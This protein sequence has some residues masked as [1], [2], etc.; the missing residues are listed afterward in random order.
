VLETTLKST[1]YRPFEAV[2]IAL[3]AALVTTCAVVAPLH[4]R[5][6]QQA[7][8]RHDLDQLTPRERGLELSSR[9]VLP[10]SFH[11]TGTAIALFPTQL[12][13][14]VPEAARQVFAPPVAGTAVQVSDVPLNPRST[15]GALLWRAG[16]CDHLRFVAGS[17][18]AAAGDIAVSAADAKTHGWRPGTRLRVAEVLDPLVTGKH[19]RARLRVTG[20]YAEPAADDPFWEGIRLS[21]P[22]GS[23]L[24][25]SRHDAWLTAAAT[26]AVTDPDDTWRDPVQTTSYRL[27]GLDVGVD[28]VRAAATGLA[29]LRDRLGERTD[30]QASVELATGLIAEAAAL[31]RAQHQAQVVVPLLMVPLGLLGLVVLW[32][33]LGTAAEQRRPE[34]AL[35]RLRGRGVG[36]ARAQLLAELMPPVVAGAVLGGAGG[37]GI[38]TVLRHRMLHGGAL[39]E[40]PPSF[41]LALGAVAAVLVVGCALA[42]N[43]VSREPVPALLRRVPPRRA[44]WALGLA[45]AAVVAAAA[46]TVAALATGS[47]TG[48]VAF[49]APALLAV[50]VGALLGRLLAPVA[51]RIGGRLLRRGR[52][53]TGVAVLH[54]GRRPATRNLLTVLTVVAALLTFAVDSISIGARNREYAAEQ[55]V[56]APMVA[57]VDGGTLPQLRRAVR[58]VDPQGRQAT[59]VIA[60]QSPIND[61]RGLFVVPDE[62]AGIARFPLQRDVRQALGRLDPHQAPPV[63]LAGTRVTF[64]LSTKDFFGNRRAVRPP[65]VLGLR[66]LR[67]D[68]SVDVV[69]AGVIPNGTTRPRPST[70][71]IPCASTCTLIGWTVSTSAS[72]I[73]HGAFTVHHLRTDTGQ[74]DLLGPAKAWRGPEDTVLGSLTPFRNAPDTLT[75][76]VGTAGATELVLTSAWVPAQFP[77]LVRGALPVGASPRSFHGPGIGTDVIE[78]RQVGRL[79][80]IPTVAGDGVLVDL[81]AVARAGTPVADLRTRQVWFAH[82]DHRLLDRLRTALAEEG[83]HVAAVHTVRETRAALAR[84]T[85]AWSLQLGLLVGAA[86]VLIGVLALLVAA[87]ATWRGRARDLAALRLSGVPPGHT[88]GIAVA[89]LLPVVVLAAL[90]GAAC[91]LVGTHYAMPTVPLFSTP[92]PVS[93][94]D[95]AAAWGPLWSSSAALLAVLGAVAWA[96][97]RD[98]DRRATLASLR[99]VR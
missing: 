18:P 59:P 4:E 27:R 25:R 69:P 92:P 3:L 88:R 33:V 57:D 96:C 37:I 39:L 55:Q 51:T 82:E 47:V 75:V 93:T 83:L 46:A 67:A 44:G 60:V 68:D 13:T 64:E 89:E 38:S 76:V 9:G 14:F 53:T 71:R 66:L 28:A 26:M 6:M 12:D 35:A 79:P 29:T 81:E 24:D 48:P 20:V 21:E 1:R 5:A 2:V 70:V 45:E 94:L 32:L 61:W 42:A 95:L 17:C 72:N 90:A 7:Q 36:G 62:F 30:T 85:P 80:R 52:A 74:H 54:A 10:T 23:A 16:A 11:P 34:L 19:H 99:E 87:I 40:L 50:A 8:L 84:S 31:R 91:G 43:R 86:G 22:P 78:M 77:A 49:A 63:R 65:V 56:G 58:A 97:G 98:V 41:W 15:E 73:G